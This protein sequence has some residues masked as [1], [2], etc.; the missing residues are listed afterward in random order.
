MK[1]QSKRL[2]LTKKKNIV[3]STFNLLH[4]EK[5][6]VTFQYLCGMKH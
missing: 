2:N 6:A 4:Y 3:H 5:F 1:Q